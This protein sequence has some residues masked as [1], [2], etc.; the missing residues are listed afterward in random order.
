MLVIFLVFWSHRST[1]KLLE[2]NP[3]PVSVS[4][5]SLCWR[6]SG[7]TH[8]PW[9]R[10]TDPQHCVFPIIVALLPL[11]FI[12][13]SFYFRQI[14][15]SYPIFLTVVSHNNCVLAVSL[16]MNDRTITEETSKRCHV[17]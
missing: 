13:P 3:E 17:I 6:S 9:E 2:K 14:F 15:D 16:F 7:S 1:T 10:V 8:H 12:D 5:V 11:P 4:C